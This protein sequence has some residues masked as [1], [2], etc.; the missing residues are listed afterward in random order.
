M[1]EASQHVRLSNELGCSFVSVPIDNVYVYG[2]AWHPIV[3]QPFELQIAKVASSRPL[4]WDSPDMVWRAE[5]VEG[6]YGGYEGSSSGPYVNGSEAP[7]FLNLYVPSKKTI[8]MAVA[9]WAVPYA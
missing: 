4:S 1:A 8:I 5:T 2:I 7:L 3:F 6:H 9:I